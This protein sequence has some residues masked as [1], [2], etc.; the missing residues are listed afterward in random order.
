VIAKTPMPRFVRTTL[1]AALLGATLAGCAPLLLGGA[2]V[3]GGL[4]A[5]DRRT[6][7]IQIE[8]EGIERRAAARVRELATL[9]HVNVTSYNRVLLIT[10][11]VPTEAD[12]QAIG[13]ALAKGENVKSVVNELG[14]GQNSSTGSRTTDAFLTTKVK[15]TLVDAKDVHA[16]AYKVVVERAVVYLMGR[17]TER[18]AARGA[19]L[20]RSVTSVQK[21]VRVFEILSEEE[22]AN[23]GRSS[24][25]AAAASGGSK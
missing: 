2:V 12:K 22:L 9:G 3:G 11:E 13:D 5:T 24:S 23:L 15:A 7:G 17:V 1:V 6:T 25:P 8:D 20:A 10:G 14:I 4:V 18:E 16:N 21:V 19:D